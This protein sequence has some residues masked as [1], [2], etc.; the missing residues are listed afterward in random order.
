MNRRFLQVMEDYRPQPYDRRVCLLRSTP[1]AAA[2]TPPEGAW[3]R[4]VKHLQGFRVG[5]G[6]LS[7][8]T[9]NA[10]EVGA[11]IQRCLDGVPHA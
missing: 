1:A 10:D 7:A 9:R 2:G 3:G 11:L 6:H 5:G 4:L 8:I